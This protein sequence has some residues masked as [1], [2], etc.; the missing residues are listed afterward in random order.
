MTDVGKFT[1]IAKSNKK[2]WS[3]RLKL[4]VI[5]V[6]LTIIPLLSLASYSLYQDYKLVN[7]V[8]EVSLA[9]STNALNASA[10]DQIE[11]RS[12][13]I[14]KE[15]AQFLYE[16]DDDARYLAKIAQEFN[17][18]LK[19]IERAFGVFVRSQKRRAVAQ[20]EWG[21]SEDG[22]KWVKKNIAN[23][24]GT[25]GSSSNITNNDT[26]NGATFHPIAAD[27]LK[28]VEVP[29]YDEVTFVGLDGKEKIKIGTTDLP[30][31][32]KV[33]FAKYFKTGDLKDVSDKKNT[34]IHAENYFPALAKLRNERGS[35]I[36][37]SDVISAYTGTNY[38][39][40]YVKDN[41]KKASDTR[42]YE[43]EYAP[44][45]Q[46]F[47]GTENPLG[48]RAEGIVRFATPVYV[49]GK[50]IGFVTLALDQDHIFEFVDHKTPM[51]ERYTE[52]SNAFDGN[53]SFIWDYQSR[54]IAHPRHASLYGFDPETGE[55]Q[56]PWLMT[57][58]YNY[59]LEKSGIYPEDAAKMTPQERI[60]HLKANWKNLIAPDTNG[61]P[62][63]NL[64]N[65]VITFRNQKRMNTSAP[66]PE[67]T[68]AS[69]LTQ[70]GFVGLDG[71]YLNNAPQCTGWLDLTK[72]GGSGSLY[73]LWSGLYKLNTAAAIPYYTGRYAPSKENNYSQVGFG[74]VA[75]GSGIE[76][77]TEPARE[78]AKV[79]DIL[80]EGITVRVF[81]YMA[82]FLFVL[83]AIAIFISFT[84]SKWLST[85]IN[86]I[87]NGIAEY[88]SGRRQFRFRSKRT[89]EF[90][91]LADSFDLLADSI[92]QSVSTS[93]VITDLEKNI[94]YMNE[95]ALALFENTTLENLV[96]KEYS[97]Y[98]RYPENSEYDP[99]LAFE[100]GKENKTYYDEKNDA[101]IK[102][103]VHNLLNNKN[104]KV[105]YI[106]ET[107]DLTEVEKRNRIVEE[108]RD[109]LSKISEELEDALKKSQD[110]IKA[111]S[112]FLANMSHEIRTPLNAIIGFSEIEMRNNLPFET[113]HNIS[114]I[115]QSGKM[116]LSI[117]NDILDISKI[118]AGQMSFN[119]VDYDLPSVINDS[120]V[121]NSVRIGTKPLQLNVIIDENIPQRLYGDDLRLKQIFNNLLSNA[122]KYSKNGTITFSV[123]S[124][125]ET[126]GGAV[127]GDSSASGASKGGTEKYCYLEC[128]VQDMGMGIAEDDI[129]KLFCDYQMVNTVQHRSEEGTGLG[130]SICKRLVDMMDGKIWVESRIGIGS[131]FSF[132]VKMKVVD[133]TPIGRELA[134]NLMQNRFLNARR[135]EKEKNFVYEN[136]PYGKILIVDDVYTNLEVAKSMMKP[137]GLNIETAMNGYEAI[138]VVKGL[139]KEFDIIFMDYMMPGMDG[140]EATKIIRE[141]GYK[142]IIVVLTANAVVGSDKMFKQSG[143]DDFISKPI[144]KDKLDGILLKY[145]RDKQPSEILQESAK[146]AKLG[147]AMQNN[148][149][150]DAVMSEM[151][152]R[153]AVKAIKNLEETV[154]SG[155]IKLFTITAHSMKSACA[156]IGENEVSALAKELEFAGIDNN[157]DLIKSKY[158]ELVE[159]LNEIVER[160]GG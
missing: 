55:P 130:L 93:I 156:N 89:D 38:I 77:F 112:V 61:K 108:Q 7:Q 100:N 155:D 94:I 47:A 85:K 24:S 51:R 127:A 99:F 18:D 4:T 2:V 131:K 15:L 68:P 91:V 17:G 143:F 128:F 117:I 70:L 98:S 158:K 75:I 74:F 36:Y 110:A 19:Q 153:D 114:K 123:K 56:I 137:Y 29:L 3:I 144:D 50:K 83:F 67:H 53:Y 57:S 92:E 20:G 142:G 10:V 25:I 109:K 147:F 37:V 22:T 141:L 86:I 152:L 46:A 5:L 148:K 81:E 138:D 71:R 160:L 34:Y 159:K 79:L 150:L 41:L 63:Y 105:G 73:I 103:K 49:N 13:D 124:R 76:S 101:Y 32:R 28:Y 48:V 104:V 21:L 116:L 97:K 96:G 80:L 43:I 111:K 118:E 125:I 139:E 95:I 90:G 121:M 35:D 44:E 157:F 8:Q 72:N 126:A 6:C 136:M 69:D 129:P 82:I 14:A 1:D 151:F 145:I 78:N 149:S 87:L 65:G 45:N 119:P 84:M 26:V 54:S 62:I 113:E 102:G 30:N 9:S 154:A 88:R 40:M 33:R 31:S 146:I 58:E 23:L 140:I 132:F 134:E 52:L 64:I 16:R 107:I 39:G 133:E 120:V 27:G 42:G 135:E 12:T 115:F 60:G 59:L 11:M 106:I 122:I 66:D